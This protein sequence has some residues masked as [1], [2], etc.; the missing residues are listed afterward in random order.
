MEAAILREVLL[1][2]SR[3]AESSGGEMAVTCQALCQGTAGPEESSPVG[4]LQPWRQPCSDS[5][6]SISRKEVND[7]ENIWVCFDGY[8]IRAGLRR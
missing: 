6:N 7:E 3:S 2:E 5:I 4:K 8:P 1:A